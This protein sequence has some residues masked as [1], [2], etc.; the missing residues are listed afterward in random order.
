MNRCI[1][2]ESDVFSPLNIF[3]PAHP[4]RNHSPLANLWLVIVAV[5][6]LATPSAHAKVFE[7]DGG[8]TAAELGFGQIAEDYF[9]NLE[10][11]FSHRW[12]VPR[13]GCPDP[14][15]DPYDCRTRLSVGLS[16]PLRLRV[17]DRQ[18]EQNSVFRTEDWDS[19]SDYFRIIR[20]IEY[21]L[22]HEAIFLR[23]GQLGPAIIGH[24]TIV[25]GYF[26]VITTDQYQ[27]G[28]QL[29]VNTPFGGFEAL[30]N[31]IIDPH[32]LA[33]RIHARPRAFINRASWWDRLAI[34]ASIV[35]DFTA[36][37]QLDSNPDG[38]TSVG[39]HDLP[40]VLT[41]QST[42]LGGLDLEL[43]LIQTEKFTLTPYTD[44]NHHFSLGTGWHNGLLSELSIS[45]N[46]RLSARVEHRLLSSR[47]LPDY[48]GPLYEIDRYQFAGWTN[49]LPAP[50]L[51]IA[52]SPHRDSVHGLFTSGTIHVHE[53]F[54]FGIAYDDYQG[55]NNSSL[56]LRMSVTPSP[57]LQLGVFYYKAN[58]DTFTDIFDFDGAL[59]ITEAR[60]LI[61]GP[62]YLK[63][64]YNRLWQ[65]QQD[66]LYTTVN[67]W[68]IGAG[69]TLAF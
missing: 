57:N 52:A 23:I 55:P 66:G 53:N 2:L 58:F 50:K 46:L 21:G 12:L 9:L 43:N 60:A 25:N 33:A 16:A 36:P 37:T 11:R 1:K 4:P 14:A 45:D 30:L 56:R 26:N 22:P 15:A 63:A 5:I 32:L 62:F 64:Q 44:L 24:G 49:S 20:H 65:L 8:S 59:I 48:I 28:S 18:P 3:R 31:N 54:A 27:L 13:A 10:L 35:S 41:Q 61:H 40:V 7:P 47:Y 29:A 39:P 69:A 17:I 34:G 67:D 19:L 42:T 68:N 38:S 6:V 51:R